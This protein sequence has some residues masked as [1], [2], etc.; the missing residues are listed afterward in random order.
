VFPSTDQYGSV[1]CG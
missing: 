1:G